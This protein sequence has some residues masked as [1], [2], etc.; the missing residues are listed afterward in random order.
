MTSRSNPASA[1]STQLSVDIIF[2]V[3]LGKKLHELRYL[4]CVSSTFANAARRVVHTRKWIWS[5]T[6]N[7]INRDDIVTLLLRAP[8]SLP[9]RLV[10]IRQSVDD[11]SCRDRLVPVPYGATATLHDLSIEKH[12]VNLGLE[13]IDGEDDSD[14]E[15]PIVMDQDALRIH[16]ATLEVDGVGIFAEPHRLAEYRS[17][18]TNNTPR[19]CSCGGMTEFGVNYFPFDESTGEFDMSWGLVSWGIIPKDCTAKYLSELSFD[20]SLGHAL[21]TGRNPSGVTLVTR[22]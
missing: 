12:T 10:K 5:S 14:G 6:Y 16:G 21:L 11:E 2:L 1:N 18:K 15:D 17:C 4:K 13:E 3:L 7:P 22:D 9:L 8:L 20:M 19:M